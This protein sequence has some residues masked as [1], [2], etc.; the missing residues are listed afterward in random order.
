MLS[1]IYLSGLAGWRIFSLCR[2]RL[3]DLLLKLLSVGTL[4]AVGSLFGIPAGLTLGLTPIL[5]GTA[6]VLGNLGA[7][8]FVV[9]AGERLQRWAYGH[10]W[11]AKRRKRLERAWNRYG[12][13]GV[14][15]LAPLITGAALGTVL[16]LALGAPPRPLLSRMCLSVVLWSAVLTGAASLGFS[17][18][19]S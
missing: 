7:L 18:F 8:I 3:L 1:A 2:I 16:A 13:L 14:A 5:A 17:M 11:L 12:V 4:G 6:S 19:R 9:L 10:R 15:L